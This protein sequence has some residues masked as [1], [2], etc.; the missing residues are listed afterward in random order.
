MTKN[1]GEVWTYMTNYVFDFEWAE[2]SHT[3]K[4]RENKDSGVNWAEGRIFV[5]RE[6]VNSDH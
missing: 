6:P 3:A 5:T 2:T 4:L 1:L